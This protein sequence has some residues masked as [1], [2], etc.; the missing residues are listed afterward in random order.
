[1]ERILL[2][3]LGANGD[4]LYATIVARQL[5]H[6]YPTAEITWAVS[7][8]CAPLLKNNPYVDQ[9]WEIPLVDWSVQ[10]Q[11][12]RLFEREAL[13]GY[14]R[15]DFDKVILSQIWPGN[16]HNYDGTVRP[17]ILRAYNGPI[18]VP[19]ENVINLTG[20]E[21]DR[22]DSYVAQS[23]IAGFEQRILFEC[24]SKSGQSFMTPELAQEVAARLYAAV[25]DATVIFS[26][27]LPMALQDPRSRE[28]SGLSLREVAHLTHHCTLFVGAGSGGTVAASS[29]AA[30]KLPMVLALSQN[31]SVF[32]SFAHDF[33]YFG[34]VRPTVVEITEQDP[35]FIADCIASACM[36]SPQIALQ[37]FHGVIPVTFGNYFSQINA[38]LLTKQLYLDAAQSLQHT[39]ARYGWTADLINFGGTRILP[40]LAQ[41]PSWVFA[42]NRARGEAF[43]AKLYEASRTPAPR[44]VQ[45]PRTV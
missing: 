36:E 6:D 38:Q 9:I 19:I 37:R 35:Q 24:N 33:E 29:T 16:L 26:T 7:N 34:I 13:R 41:D 12:W 18:T 8:Q 20:E 40:N 31:T 44:P 15:H 14:I 39:A 11:A 45:S 10:V 21:I 3:Q 23:G 22:V 2:G 1:L 27:H 32:A 30:A 17:S 42:K 25:P 43:H 4:C 5:R 28:V